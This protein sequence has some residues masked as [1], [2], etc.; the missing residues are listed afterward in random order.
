MPWSRDQVPPTVGKKSVT[1]ANNGDNAA[2]SDPLDN[3]HTKVDD[4][5]ETI[6]CYGWL[7]EE[8]TLTI[9]SNM[10]EENS[11]N[12]ETIQEQQATDAVLQKWVKE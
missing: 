7:L 6:T 3:H 1:L 2:N 4:V 12:M 11:L 9:P 5:K 10:D 8:D